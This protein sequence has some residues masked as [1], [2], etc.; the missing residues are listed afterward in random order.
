MATNSATLRSS[1]FNFPSNRATS[2]SS[3]TRLRLAPVKAQPAP[4]RSSDFSFDLF[5]ENHIVGK[6]IHSYLPGDSIF[7]QGDSSHS[8]YY[9]QCGQVK[10][11]VVSKSGKEAV[12]A[13]LPAGSY[14]G[15]SAL[16][17]EPLR[18]ASASSLGSSTIVRMDRKVMRELLQRDAGFTEH[19][20]A[21]LVARKIRME[22]DYVDQL[23]NSSEKRLARLLLLMANP[24]PGG[25][26]PATIARIS[27]ETLAEMIGTT[28]SRV[29]FFLNRF[30]ELGYV[31]YDSAG[32]RVKSSLKNVV[33]Q[34]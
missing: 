13:H 18:L 6:T 26:M 27:Q 30:R 28:R 5:L 32:M 8:V 19:F 24:V 17:G 29:S 33:L 3:R 20:M 25:T 34:A 21:H 7:L 23:F 9:I 2:D 15:E 12:I 14:F 11:T 4:Q 31:E 1:G 22:A 10:L 16:A